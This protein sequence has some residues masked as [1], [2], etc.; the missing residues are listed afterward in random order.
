[1]SVP[2]V[3]VIAVFVQPALTVDFRGADEIGNGV[4]GPHGVGSTV[5]IGPPGETLVPVIERGS[6]A[7]VLEE[8]KD[9]MRAKCKIC[10]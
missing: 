8:D 4:A 6:E 10:D 5:P 7:V 1:M 2:Q 9:A 3:A